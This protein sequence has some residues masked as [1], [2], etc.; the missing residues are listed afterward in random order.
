MYDTKS[1]FINERKIIIKQISKSDLEKLIVNGIIK[2]T[3][4]GF[5]NEDGSNVAFYR[6]K[7][8]AKKRWIQD[9]YADLAKTL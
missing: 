4:R 2:N 1:K 7:G 6:T 3:K 9:A 8:C 5:I